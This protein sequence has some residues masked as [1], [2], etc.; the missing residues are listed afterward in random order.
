MTRD[1]RKAALGSWHARADIH[2][3]RCLM[4]A[5]DPSQPMGGQSGDPWTGRSAPRGAGCFAPSTAAPKGLAGTLEVDI[6]VSP[7]V[8]R[9]GW[10]AVGLL[11]LRQR[12]ERTFCRWLG[13]AEKKNGCYGVNDGKNSTFTFAGSN[14]SSRPKADL[15]TRASAGSGRAGAVIRGKLLVML[16]D[17]L[18]SVHP[19]AP[20]PR[21]DRRC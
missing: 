7:S 3:P 1:G 15:H 6:H 14:R 17:R 12:E 19:A 18:T 10:R 4:S 9:D 2:G 20:S 13:L 8:D 21:S 5:L 16:P 11:P